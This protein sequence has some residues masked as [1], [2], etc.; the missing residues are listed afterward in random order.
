MFLMQENKT[1]LHLACTKGHDDVVRILLAFKATVNTQ[2]K[3]SH[4]SAIL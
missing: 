2:D 3:V 1:P 4:R